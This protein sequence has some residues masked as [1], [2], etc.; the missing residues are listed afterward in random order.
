MKLDKVNRRKFYAA[1]IYIYKNNQ[2]LY[3]QLKLELKYNYDVL[4]V[5]N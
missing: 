4:S 3:Y 1:F 2:C 5:N